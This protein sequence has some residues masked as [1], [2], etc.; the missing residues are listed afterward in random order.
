MNFDDVMGYYGG[1][2]RTARVLG[3][4]KQTVFAWKERRIPSW[5]QATLEVES[6]GELRADEETA[7][8]GRVYAQLAA[9]RKLEAA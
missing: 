4:A 3:C 5:W 8:D 6:S 1:I 9:F 2:T 7:K